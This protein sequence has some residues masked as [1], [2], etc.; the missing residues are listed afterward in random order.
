M[1]AYLCAVS[2]CA[3][4]VWYAV[5]VAGTIAAVAPLRVWERAWTWRRA[6]WPS[7]SDTPP[8]HSHSQPTRRIHTYIHTYNRAHVAPL[9]S[10][11]AAVL[12]AEP[13]QSNFAVCGASGVVRLRRADR[14]FHSWGVE[15]CPFLT[16][17]CRLPS[18]PD[19]SASFQYATEHRCAVLLRG[20]HL[21]DCISGTDPL[22]D[23]RALLHCRPTVPRDHPEYAAAE[24]TSAVVNELSGA[25]SR[26][27]SAHPL[28]ERRRSAGLPYTNLVL[29]RGAGKRIAVPRFTWPTAAAAGEAAGSA[30]V[31]APTAIIGGLAESLDMRRVQCEGAT[32]DYRTDLNAKAEE[33]ARGIAHS[34][35]SF[36]LLHVKVHT[37]HIAA[38]SPTCALRRQQLHSCTRARHCEEQRLAAVSCAPLPA[39]G[40][41]GCVCQAVDDAGHDRSVARKAEWIGRV[42]GMVGRLVAL[43]D[44]SAAQQQR[45]A[46]VLVVTADHS[47]PVL[48][49]DHAHE[50][51]PVLM[52]AVG[53]R[54][55]SESDTATEQQA[56]RPA[57]LLSAL[58]RADSAVQ[59]FDEVSCSR[60]V[61]GRFPGSELLPAVTRFC[62]LVSAHFR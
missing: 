59:R 61:L 37:A 10:R 8:P 54:A 56:A 34:Q 20:P 60:G 17:H 19:V 15:L 43:L 49:G 47:T 23:G 38:R 45:P 21:S 2:L 48:Y 13:C 14:S 7:K 35:H 26:L 16:A 36:G 50:P 9:T 12:C 42:D 46:C 18:F 5:R 3:R 30:F 33:A 29:L 40:L 58:L 31:I 24:R 25:V 4:V 51:V 1:P 41:L 44:S 55:A 27:L 6:T 11:A 57:S 32:G 62:N 28:V 39:A 53:G 52:A 22:V